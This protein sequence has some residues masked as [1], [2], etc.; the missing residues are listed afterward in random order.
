M[1]CHLPGHADEPL[2]AP[3]TMDAIISGFRKRLAGRSLARGTVLIGESLS[4]LALL[5][6]ASGPPQ[7]VA[8]V[9]ALDPPLTIQKHRSLQS[10]YRKDWDELDPIVRAYADVFGFS[11]EDGRAVS[12]ERDYRGLLSSVNIPVHIVAGGRRTLA[13]TPMS[14]LDHDDR[15]L[16]R[17]TP[18]V[19]LHEMG[20]DVGH[21]LLAEDLENTAR[22]VARIV[23]ELAAA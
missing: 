1:V 14:L 7:G 19:A 17:A 15:A 16:I 10:I 11:V 6:L 12:E 21:S 13:A 18:G 4:G 9:V 5:G 3:V 20:A 22:V 8:G 2:I 23:A